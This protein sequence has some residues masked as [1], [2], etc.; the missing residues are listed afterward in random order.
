MHQLL[1]E[2]GEI[3]DRL[4]AVKARQG[5]GSAFRPG[6]EAEMMRRIVE[7][8]RGLL[9]LDTVES[10]WRVIISTFTYVQANYSVHATIAAGDAAMRDRALPF[11]L[12]RALSD[13][14]RRARRDRGRGALVRR[15]R[16]GRVDAGTAAGAW[17]SALADP[18]APKIIARLPFVERPT[19]PPAAGVRRLATAGR[20]RG[21]AIV[22][23]WS[24]SLDRW[25]RGLPAAL[26][27]LGVE[28][29]GNA[30]AT[31]SALLASR[32][33]ARR[34]RRGGPASRAL[35]E[36][37]RRAKRASPRSAAMR[38]DIP[39]TARTTSGRVRLIVPRPASGVVDM[40]AETPIRPAPRPGVLAIDAYVPGKSAAAGG[41]K[42]T[43]YPPTR[44]RSAP[45]RRRSRRFTRL[46][47]SCRILSRRHGA[48]A[49]RGDRRA[50][51][52]RPR[53]A[54]SAARARTTSSTC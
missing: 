24:L 26:G 34:G 54:S 25:S 45:R 31:A 38:R 3:I 7:R 23:I 15:S 14:S 49:A 32:V 42:S 13:A 9:P 10:I 41:V 2:R 33:N 4:I 11:R 36:A 50:L 30:D 48:Q 35:A 28:I 8:H 20:G 47:G 17:W 40:T 22:V 21:R 51:R 1:M 29:I 6:R 16:H 18:A 12:H 44:R 43:N 39:F 19:I 52:A 37:G 46:R 53:R 27:A 5:G